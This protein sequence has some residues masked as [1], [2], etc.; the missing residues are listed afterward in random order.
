MK[1][2]INNKIA[3]IQSMKKF[4]NIWEGSQIMFFCS[5]KKSHKIHFIQFIIIIA[6]IIAVLTI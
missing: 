1:S 2:G 3:Y 4:F 6:I 5:G